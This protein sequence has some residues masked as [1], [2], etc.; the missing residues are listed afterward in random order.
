MAKAFKLPKRIRGVKLP[1]A[2]RKKA[3][4]LLARLQG[5]ELRALAG[6]V[7]TAVI[8]HLVD[9]AGQEKLSH[10]LGKA[11]GGHLIK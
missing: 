3:N 5:E 11:V 7:A 1:K 8:T 6:V 2:E 10:R 4:R 9:Q